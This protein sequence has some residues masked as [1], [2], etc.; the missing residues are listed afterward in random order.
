MKYVAKNPQL[1]EAW[2][3]EKDVGVPVWVARK[4]H[5][6]GDGKLTC[7]TIV[8][9]TRIDIGDYVVMVEEETNSIAVVS[10]EQFEAEFQP[11]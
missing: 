1:V 2:K 4:C 5:D 9:P 8:G 3:Y 11:A 6:L 7:N 10:S